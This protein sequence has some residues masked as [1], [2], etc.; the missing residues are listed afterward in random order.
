MSVTF[1]LTELS[2]EDRLL[3]LCARVSLSVA[4]QE[5]L[6]ELTAG[7]LAWDVVLA[8]GVRHGIPILVFHHLAALEGLC[9]IPPP[10]RECFAQIEQVAILQ[11]MRQ[12]W[13]IIRL[14]DR[15]RAAGIAVI[16]LKGL[17]LRET[18]YPD[19]VLRPSGDMD[20][21]VRAGDVG[22]AGETLL[23]LGYV[24]DE[25]C[26][27]ADWYRPEHTHHLVPYRLPGRELLVEVHWNLAPPEARLRID[28]ENL[29]CRAVAGQLAGR[30]VQML[31]PADLVL[32]LALHAAT[33]SHSLVRLRHL[34]DLAATANRL[35]RQLNGVELAGRA[36][37]WGGQAQVYLILR[38]TQALLEPDGLTDALT[39][40]RPPRFDDA[41]V[42]AA[43]RRV[44]A[45]GRLEIQDW[46]TEHLI[47]LAVAGSLGEKLRL[48]AQAF[49]PSRER[50]AQLY[51]LPPRSR[52]LLWC[53]LV[54]PFHLLR[55]YVPHIRL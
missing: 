16:L 5:A 45:L 50:M 22:K 4:D 34:T 19:P 26:H 42:A 41:Q 27:P 1:S 9:P 44:M 55:R 20:L 38:V 12:R 33:L 47:A 2:P 23:A 49:F 3:L 31:A 10:I 36:A 54:R 15:L 52:R 11:V 48:A 13:E 46:M 6:I 25:T 35:R 8:R 32:H 18:I 28:I 37:A 51:H 24:A 53:Y 21:L 29:W 14:L 40:L 43:A 7:P 30:P 39:V 17:A